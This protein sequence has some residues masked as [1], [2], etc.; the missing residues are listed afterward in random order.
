MHEIFNFASEKSI[1][2]FLLRN[3][4]IICIMRVIGY[5]IDLKAV[6]KILLKKPQV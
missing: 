6:A 3:S 1:Y 2:Q 4:L 5:V